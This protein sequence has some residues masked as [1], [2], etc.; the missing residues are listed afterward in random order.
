MGAAGTVTPTVSHTPWAAGCQ[1]AVGWSTF[2]KVRLVRH[3][4]NLLI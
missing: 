3:L 4:A 1:D 2:S